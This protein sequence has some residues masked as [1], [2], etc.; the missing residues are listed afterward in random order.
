M[1]DFLFEIGCEEI[2]A[3][4]L[5][6]L[7]QALADNFTNALA[8]Q[9]VAFKEVKTYTSPRR[10]AVHIVDINN[11]SDCINNIKRG[12]K[13]AIA[14]EDGIAG[15]KLTAAGQGFM[16]SCGITNPQDTN[17]KPDPTGS[18]LIFE[19]QQGGTATASLLPE[20][21]T[22]AVTKLAGFK[23]MRWGQ[24]TSYSFIRPVLWILALLDNQVIPVQLFG[25]TS[26]NLTY[27]H[28]VHHPG[29]IA[30]DK[31]T[32]YLDILEHQGHVIAD[33][34]T[35]KNL[36]TQ[37]ASKLA[38]NVNATLVMPPELLTEVTN[39][40]ELPVAVLGEFDS[41]Y[42]KLP[43][44][45]LIAT[46]EKH[47]KFFHLLDASRQLLPYFISIVNLQASKMEL[48]IK[49]NHKVVTARLEDAWF[50]YHQ[51]TQTKLI[52][53]QENLKQLNFAPNLG[54]VYDKTTRLESLTIY[55]CSQLELNDKDSKRSASLCKCDLVTN[56][57]TELTALQGVIGSY[58]AQED[59]ENKAVASA[60][61]QQYLPASI[62]GPLPNTA[63]ASIL[64]LAD[65]LD[66]LV[67]FFAIGKQPTGDKDPFALR[68]AA[69][70]IIRIILDNQWTL[71]LTQIITAASAGYQ[72]QNIECSDS[73]QSAVLEFI[74]TRLGVYYRDQRE[75]TPQIIQAVQAVKPH[76]LVDFAQRIDAVLEFSYLEVAATLA[77]SNKRVRNL[78]RKNSST[79]QQKIDTQLLTEPAEQLLHQSILAKEQAHAKDT[80]YQAILLDLADLAQPVDNFFE[81]VMVMT[82]DDK[83][84]Q[85]RLAL[86][87]KLRSLFLTAA[88]ISAL[89]I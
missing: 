55:L 50:F 10:I 2:P 67:G 3:N 61:A 1:A 49:G 7:T 19:Q 9:H 68:R 72:V 47:Q 42:L 53:K 64:A 4:K 26:G 83:I 5:N 24:D 71:P 45:V 36:I 58:Y 56:L 44:E 29:A 41:K 12:P 11:T 34:N 77:A 32:N 21:I 46:I 70:G 35:R 8:Q 33:V 13:I 16:R 85:N 76:N 60:I 14:Y 17:L 62:N 48:V 66:T 43:S 88:D 57:V 25:K 27:G 22:N 74:E 6:P 82:D 86:L 89:D 40:V 59:G 80:D 69:L 39:L 51:D 87:G 63:T 75:I 65:R 81:Q 84:K 23:F 15:S 28:R 54:S 79:G 78:L 52:D 18:W 30:I 31:I 38:K 20:I 37:Q 73:S